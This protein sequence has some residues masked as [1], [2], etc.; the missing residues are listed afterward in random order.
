MAGGKNGKEIAQAKINSY[1]T[2]ME[3]YKT[4]WTREELKAY[5]LLY[6]SSADFEETAA[7]TNYINSKFKAL[8]IHTIRTE[9]KGDN[10]YQHIK[11][12][13]SAM[14]RLHYTREGIEVLEKEMKELFLIDGSYDTLEKN[15]F[16]GLKRILEK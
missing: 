9:F 2:K 12:I 1:L 15:L 6:C 3:E 14:D 10:D 13:R 11:K 7:E 16:I 4:K 8:N 5:L